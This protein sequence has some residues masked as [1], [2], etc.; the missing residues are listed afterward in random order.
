MAVSRLVAPVY[1]ATG[2]HLERLARP[3]IARALGLRIA[4]PQVRT[5]SRRFLA[6][7]ASCRMLDLVLGKLEAQGKLGCSELIGVENL[8]EALAEGKGVLVA[9]GHFFGN[10]AAKRYLASLGYPMLSVRNLHPPDP[11]QMTAPCDPSK[12]GRHGGPGLA[13]QDVVPTQD[14]D[15]ALK[16]FNR[17]RSGG[18]VNVHYDAAQPRAGSEHPFLGARSCFATGFLKIAYHAGSPIVPMLCLIGKGGPR[19][20]F[21]PSLAIPPGPDPDKFVSRALSRLVEL[22]ESQILRYPEQWAHWALM[23][24]AGIAGERKGTRDGA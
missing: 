7:S 1:V 11:F 21:Q 22:L 14:A 15:C 12:P 17:L 13:L 18:L 20:R 2:A 19:I 6:N 23:G 24:Q 4:D 9:S 3:H 10:R 8:T 16:V 5:I